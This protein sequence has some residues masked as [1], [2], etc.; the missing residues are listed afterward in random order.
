M[1]EHEQGVGGTRPFPIT[2]DV[3]RWLLDR[4]LLDVDGVA[5]GKIDDL[6]FSDP[7]PGQAPELVALLRGP[8]ALGPRI[9][10]RLGVWW[11]AIGLRLRAGQERDAVRIPVGVVAGVHHAAVRL[12]AHRQAL[13]T[14]AIADLVRDR[15]APRIPGSG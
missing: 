7:V 4:Q 15:A 13:G 1:T 5:C 11:T 6:E 9:G 2:L 14:D 10:G 3:D 8:A 12:R